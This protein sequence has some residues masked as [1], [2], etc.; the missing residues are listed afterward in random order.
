MGRPDYPATCG[1]LGA[2]LRFLHQEERR[3]AA[4]AEALYRSIDGLVDQLIPEYEAINGAAQQLVESLLDN[5]GKMRSALHLR[6]CRMD[7]TSALYRPPVKPGFTI[8]EG[9]LT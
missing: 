7:P 4:A 3:L 8:N 1:F 6:N 9:E 5:M 2:E